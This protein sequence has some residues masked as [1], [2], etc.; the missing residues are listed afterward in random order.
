MIPIISRNLIHYISFNGKSQAN[1][2]SEK[3][4]TLRIFS[5]NSSD[6]C[7]VIGEELNGLSTPRFDPTN[8]EEMKGVEWDVEEWYWEQRKRVY[9]IIAA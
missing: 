1:S 7:P 8:P 2:Q 6:R 3:F 9:G 4:T 5:A